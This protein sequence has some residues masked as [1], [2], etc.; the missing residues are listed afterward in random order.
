MI[1]LKSVIFFK[2]KLILSFEGCVTYTSCRNMG[3]DTAIIINIDVPLFPNIQLISQIL[4]VL[5]F[6]NSAFRFIL[7]RFRFDFFSFH[8]FSH[9]EV[10]LCVMFFKV[11]TELF[12]YPIC[13]LVLT[14]YFFSP[15][16]CRF[17]IN[18]LSISNYH[19]HSFYSLRVSCFI[20]ESSQTYMLTIDGWRINGFMHFPR[21]FMRK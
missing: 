5:H 14:E 16:F 11:F 2:M 17:I 15:P 1:L 13:V 20:D 9:I 3:V 19:Q 10:I 18:F 6:C 21:A 4:Y 8:M 12:H 7:S